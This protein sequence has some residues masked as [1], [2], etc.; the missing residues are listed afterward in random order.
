MRRLVLSLL[1]L[2]ALLLGA[3]N[4]ATAQSD[5]PQVYMLYLTVDFAD[6]PT[7]I[8]N[9]QENE[10]PLLDSLV[11]EG[12]LMA[13]DLWV[14]DTGGGYNVRYNY[15]TPNWAAIGD[16]WDGYFARS[17]A[18]EVE[19]WMSMVRDHQ[20]EIWIIKDSN[21]PQGRSPSPVIYESSFHVAYSEQEAWGEDFAA[22]GKPALERAMEEGLI[23]AWAELVHNTGGVDNVR[24]IYWMESWDAIDDAVA[25]IGEVRVELG[26]TMESARMIRGHSDNV[27]RA[28]SAM[29]AAGN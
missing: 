20:D 2:P 24:Y 15:V 7:W 5:S 19:E 25:R 28:V 26:Q 12:T 4:P 3:P 10:V 9:Y 27:W 11:E 6:L 18:D 8:E 13:Y 1:L 21:I 23:D 14:H 22:H 17:G 29:E 16:F